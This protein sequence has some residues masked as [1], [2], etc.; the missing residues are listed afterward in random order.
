MNCDYCDDGQDTSKNIPAR[1]PKAQ[2][3]WGNGRIMSDNVVDDDDGDGDDDDD[4][5]DD[6]DDDDDDES[7]SY[8]VWY[9]P[10]IG[11]LY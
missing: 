4:D 5:D 7:G 2:T 11:V 6:C 8:K 9:G 1:D 10:Y 3:V